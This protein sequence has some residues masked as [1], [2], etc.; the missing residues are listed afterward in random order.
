LRRRLKNPATFEAAAAEMRALADVPRA[1]AISAQ[2]APVPNPPQVNTGDLLEQ[3]IDAS[4]GQTPVA[5]TDEILGDWQGYLR[6]LAAPHLV[7][8]AHPQAQPFIA[9]LEAA[10]GE[11]MRA[12][13]HDPDFQELE[14]AWRAVFFLVHRLETGGELKLYLVDVSKAELAADLRSSEDLSSS[15]LYHLLVK[16]SAGSQ[17]AQPWAV[18][19][20]NY[21]FDGS[22][23][24]VE[25]LGRVAKIAAQTRAPFFAAASPQIVGC[26]SLAQA[27]DPDDWSQP[28][29][30]DAWDAL[31]QL[32]EATSLGLALP[33]FLLRLPYGKETEP[34]ERFP[35]EEVAENPEHAHYLWGNPAFACVYL[36]AEAFGPQGWNMRPGAVREIQSLPLHTYQKDSESLV[37]P[38]AETLL[39]EKAA[40]RLLDQGLMPLLSFQG[41]D[42]VRLAR[43]QSVANPLKPLA[44]RWTR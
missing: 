20:G 23:E 29:P 5:K 40:E 16:R 13:L 32:P 39:S 12:I 18:L 1:S 8:E 44:G 21:T 41:R 36:L 7:P 34:I 25:L 26:E 31:R 30:R 6:R 24:D 27:P 28:A 38:C 22:V 42:V 43:F 4:P 33:R 2:S 3:I 14:A 19:A 37:K 11:Q 10:M 15:A 17:D 9:H 35:F